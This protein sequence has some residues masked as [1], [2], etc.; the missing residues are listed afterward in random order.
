MRTNL[1]SASETLVLFGLADVVEDG[2]GELVT[3]KVEFEL[4]SLDTN[5]TVEGGC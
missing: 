2:R 5:V 1:F 4:E 3:A